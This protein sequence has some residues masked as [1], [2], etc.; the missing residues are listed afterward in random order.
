MSLNQGSLNW[1]NPWCILG[2]FSLLFLL[3]LLLFTVSFIIAIVTKGQTQ[4]ISHI[5]W[6][7][8]LCWRLD[9]IYT[10]GVDDIDLLF[11]SL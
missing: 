4:F 8:K 2:W 7:L 3:G 11:E 1:H 9:C 5:F 6:W 10:D